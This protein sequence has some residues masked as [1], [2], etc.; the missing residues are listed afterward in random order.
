MRF[1]LFAARNLPLTRVLAA[2]L[3]AL[4]PVAAHADTAPTEAA[5]PVPQ[6]RLPDAVTPSAYRLDLSVDPAQKRFSGHVEID[7]KVAA[8]TRFVYIHG[9]DLGVN[10]AAATVAGRVIT[11]TW[12]QVDPSG[13]ALLTFPEALPAGP[14]TLSFDYDAP[15]QD[16]P[17]GLFHIKVGDTWYSWSQFESTDAR[18]AYPS[19]DQPGYKQP[20]TVTLRTPAGLSAVSNAPEASVE[21]QGAVD[22]HHF[23]TTLPL[24]TYLLALMVGPFAQDATLIPATPQRPTPLPLRIITTQQNADS[25]SFAAQ[26]TPSIIQH[27]EAYFGQSF[28]YPKLDAITTP[29]L[30]GAMENAGADLFADPLLILDD[31]AS[32]HQKREFGM[33]VAHELAHQWFGDL[34]TPAWWDDIWLNES[35]AN[36]MGYRIGNEWRPDLGIGAGANAEAFA[37][38]NT[39]ALLAGRPIHQ[40]IDRTAQIDAAFDGITYG[41]GGQVVA[42]IAAFMGDDKF[43]D[44][45]RAYMA[46]HRYGN[47]TSADFFKAMADVAGDP[48]ILPAMQSFTDQQGVPLLTFWM[49]ESVFG[50][51]WQLT[52]SRYARLGTQAPET[53]WTVPICAR[54]GQ[55]RQCKLLDG[56]KGAFFFNTGQ[57]AFMPNASGTG[58]YRF[59]FVGARE[60]PGH[61][62]WD[63][64]IAASAHLPAGEA[65]A[66]SDSLLA[67]FQAGRAHASQ[68]AELARVMSANPDSHASA[69]ATTP[70]GWVAGAGLL[71]DKAMGSYRALVRR[72]YT[73]VLAGLGFDPR[74]GAYATEDPER[75]QRRV[76]TVTALVDTARDSKLRGQLLKATRAALAGD[77]KALDPVWYG[78]GL[79]LWLTDGGKPAAQQLLERALASQSPLLRPAA[80]NALAGTGRQDI[81]SWLL[82]DVHDDRLRLSERMD[83]VSSI[84]ATR[85]TREY[86]Y[87]WMHEHLDALLGGHAGIF[88]ASR[89]PQVFSSYCEAGRVAEITRDF[90]PKLAG[91]TSQLELERALERVTDCAKL[92]DARGQEASAEIAKLR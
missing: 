55:E 88:F 12:K 36:W 71:N 54:E 4:A 14:V 24:P 90:G 5:P 29:I 11:A 30:P 7:A 52:Q 60:N 8:P 31:K 43:R 89:L 23:A 66:L 68:L 35:F 49:A 65:L 3:L 33:V 18:A 9:R 44:G 47:A 59:E 79:P 13:V 42:M 34:V 39:D 21:H 81:A 10:R 77:A 82:N 67:S 27:L 48:R 76:D 38:M 51:N 69:A 83:M 91:Q 86:G 45:V 50:S 78:L 22:V 32:T 40:R 17:E 26:N 19:F 70:I 62:F 25:M 46:A 41:K 75:Q 72:I 6:G 56:T 16:G 53:T 37:A 87:R 85:D 73:P 15:F 1:S 58:Y 92:K 64:L 84:A 28:P 57:G 2:S 61:S 80:L 20:F 63:A 74:A